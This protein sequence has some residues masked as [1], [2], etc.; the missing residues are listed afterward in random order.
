M[1]EIE[2]KLAEL[3]TRET[4]VLDWLAK[5]N[6]TEKIQFALEESLRRI[7]QDQRQLLLRQLQSEKGPI[8]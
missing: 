1:D 5:G 8:V 3:A 2:L 6:L 4:T 7:R